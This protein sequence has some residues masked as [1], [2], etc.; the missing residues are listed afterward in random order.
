MTSKAFEN[1]SVDNLSTQSAEALVNAYDKGGLANS[2]AAEVSDSSR[3]MGQ[4]NGKT[5]PVFEA[6]GQKGEK[7]QTNLKAAIDTIKSNMA[8]LQPATPSVPPLQQNQAPQ[9]VAQPT[10]SQAPSM[11]PDRQYAIKEQARGAEAPKPDS[12]SSS[13]GGQTQ[14]PAPQVNVTVQ[15]D[16]SSDPTSA[17]SI[18]PSYIDQG[19]TS[20]GG[21]SQHRRN[22]PPTAFGR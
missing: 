9:G 21:R 19:G 22:R 6:L 18:P 4:A 13:S 15:V 12:L 20:G 1:L 10:P 3:Y 11:A 16:R 8:S 14:A 2:R 5:A 17:T 7:G